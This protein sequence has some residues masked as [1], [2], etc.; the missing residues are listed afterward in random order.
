MSTN[1]WA[2]A[3]V[4]TRFPSTDS[5][6]TAD[7]SLLVLHTMHTRVFN[8]STPLENWIVKWILLLLYLVI[9]HSSYLYGRWLQAKLNIGW[10]QHPQIW[11]C[12]QPKQNKSKSKRERYV[13][14]HTN[15]QIKSTNTNF[16]SSTFV[17]ILTMY[18]PERF[19]RADER[20]LA[21]FYLDLCRYFLWG[22]FFLCERGAFVFVFVF[23]SLHTS[24][25]CILW[26]WSKNKPPND[27]VCTVS[28][29]KRIEIK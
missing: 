22:E 26:T 18:E 20:C 13:D 4:S 24:N 17:D 28:K 25:Q 10:K 29:A 23:V 27:W 19:V 1:T 6:S 5:H 15:T 16:I 9:H 2:R 11:M 7:R 3:I 14:A 8:I 12:V 21:T